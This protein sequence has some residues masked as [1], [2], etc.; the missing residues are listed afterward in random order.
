MQLYQFEK[1]FSQMG[2][3]FGKM[4]DGEEVG[5]KL[6]DYYRSTSDGKGKVFIGSKVC[7]DS[8]V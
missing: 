8:T 5:D 7:R 6:P 2:K 1:I 3:E 4:K